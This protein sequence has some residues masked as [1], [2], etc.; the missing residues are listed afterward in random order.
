M[1]HIK[2]TF[3]S[4]T[5]KVI[6]KIRS[7]VKVGTEQSFEEINEILNKYDKYDLVTIITEFKCTIP[8]VRFRN[9]N[10]SQVIASINIIAIDEFEKNEA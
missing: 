3:S 4:D 5:R 6:N 1:E 9:K 10:K 7:L 2:L 8:R